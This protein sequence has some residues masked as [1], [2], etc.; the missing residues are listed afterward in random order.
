MFRSTIIKKYTA[1]FLFIYFFFA[2][3]CQTVEETKVEP[4]QADLA[5]E[6]GEDFF[7]DGDTRGEEEFLEVTE[8]EQ[9]IER[10]EEELFT[11]EENGG[12][13]DDD[14]ESEFSDSE[15]F[16]KEIVEEAT[17]SGEGIAEEES[18]EAGEE[19]KAAAEN[20]EVADQEGKL[21]EDDFAIEEEDS[22]VVS[23]AEG[24]ESDSISDLDSGAEKAE[25]D[26]TKPADIVINDIRYESQENK[27]YIGGT[28]SFSYQSRENT[29]SNQFVIEISG[30]VLSEA[31]RERPFVMKDFSTQIALL[32]ADQKDSNTVRIVA[33]M[34][35][36]AGMPSASLA[37]DGS[38]VISGG[39]GDMVADLPS[40]DSDSI[41]SGSVDTVL[42]AKS[43]EE[44]FLQ[45]SQFTGSPISIHLQDVSVRDVLYFISEGTGLNMVVSDDV[46]GTISIKLRNVPWDQALV[47][48]M[49]TKKL[50]YVREGNVIRIM[51][52]ATLKSDQ[53]SIKKMVESQKA[54][55]PLKVKV[56][57]L[58]YTKAGDMEA[59]AK[60]FSTKDR[61][62]IMADTQSN[63]L[64]ITD[65]ISAIDLI[66]KMIKNMDRSPLQVMIEAK[67]VEARERFVRNLGVNWTFTG[68]PLTF[69]NL[70]PDLALNA[71]GG[72]DIFPGSG[73]G[74]GRTVSSNVNIGFAPVGNLS[75]ILGL[76]EAEDLV[77]V[78]S[79]PRV[80]VLNGE[81]AKITQSTES[82]D[83]NVTTQPSGATTVSPTRP[84]A[85]LNF[86]VTPTITA[87]GSVFMEITVKREF[88]G[89]PEPQTGSRPTNTREAKTKVLVDNGQTIV[90]GGI[91]QHDETSSDEGIPIIKH[92]PILKWLFS[93]FT[94]DE[95]RNELLVF[96]TPRVI[97]FSRPQS[98]EIN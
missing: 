37:E 61:G 80:M 20:Q 91:Y 67:I 75:L 51:S 68:A 33:Q 18:E 93:R 46:S 52:L 30:A 15:E 53:E 60:I 78:I 40:G 89:A 32:Q 36:N 88:F 76:S 82:I 28:G 48:V 85:Q 87:I 83:V 35:E 25:E 21:L 38:L 77:H 22:D 23:D 41:G 69:P 29:Q 55:D 31:L 34:R 7:E 59:K 56:I 16:E 97:N 5:V 24:E 19:S 66:E 6:E 3:S 63:S 26:Q 27:I 54:L 44:F 96:L 70:P 9:E 43:L 72:L 1:L 58:I 64:I 50:G 71:G 17:P 98:L 14:L 65:T 86:E 81:S 90:I 62:K 13:K 39:E 49:K 10:E 95:E 2:V 45:S 8:E 79:A 73:G 94:T 11:E 84:S 12:E 57:P 42:P 74:S 47:T 4:Q 92:I